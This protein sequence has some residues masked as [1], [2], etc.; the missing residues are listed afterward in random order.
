MTGSSAFNTR[1]RAE[2]RETANP[3]SPD[4]F[5]N[6]E[7]GWQTL[8]ARWAYVAPERGRE[9]LAAG[10]LES[11]VPALVRLRADGDTRG[12]DAGDRLI[13][14]TGPNA[15]KQFEIISVIK[16]DAADIEMSGVIGDI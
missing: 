2:R 9:A 12:L 1:V 11:R 7:T 3:D 8:F 13:F 10:R 6:V 4:D 15:G 5:G 14:I 16:A